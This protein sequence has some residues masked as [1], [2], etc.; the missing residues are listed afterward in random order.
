M[1][2]GSQHFVS[3]P[4]VTPFP[5]GRKKQQKK[6]QKIIVTPFP[7]GRKKE[8]KIMNSA[9]FELRVDGSVRMCW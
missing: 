7:T 1:D 3:A 8:Q 9:G 6:E 4:T 5:T 2:G